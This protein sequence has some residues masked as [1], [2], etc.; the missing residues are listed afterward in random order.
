[1]TDQHDLGPDP[2]LDDVDRAARRA[3]DGLRAHV[4]RTVEP[5]LLL[6]ALPPAAPS[7][8]RGRLLAAAAVAAL[9]IGTVAVIGDGHP[10][11]E[12]SRLEVDEDGNKLPAPQAG[13]L[14]ALGPSD[15]RDSIQL[16]VTVEPNADL[17]DGD[18]VTAN[19]PG[20]VAGERVGIVQCASE[21]GEGNGGTREARVGIDA[22]DVGGVAYANADADGVATGTFTVH[23]VLTTPATGTVDCAAEARRCIVAMGALQDYDRS[24]GFGLAFRGGGEPVD[25]PTVTVSPTDGLS[26][27]DVVHV[28]GKG[29]AP[30]P[31]SLSECAIDPAGCWTVGEPFA[32]TADEVEAAGLTEVF[33]G[34]YEGVGLVADAAGRVSGDVPVWRFL[35]TEDPSSY[36]DCAVSRC[37][38]RFTSELGGHS[39]AP[40]ALQFRS[41]GAAPRP[42]AIAVSPDHDVRRGQEIVVRGA[43]FEPGADYSISMCAGRPGDP[44][45]VYACV[46]PDDQQHQIEDDG[47]FAR[48]FQ[49]PDISGLSG[50]V[51]TTTSCADEATC[52][53]PLPGPEQMC[54]GVHLACTI[55][56]DV[57]SDGAV[58][59]KPQFQA[60][61]V[62]VTLRH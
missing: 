43:G 21:A 42:P 23:R 15:G 60:V 25:I 12:R 59:G 50:E 45:E 61:P 26:D 54:D 27:G 51:P 35:P 30:G 44:A 47:G 16:P 18:V 6:A 56:V 14:T 36:I 28:E 32:L 2:G 37:T 29:F 55:R 3:S 62:E 49:V 9:L 40:P 4:H 38:L 17:D 48:L 34:A 11:D 24:G 33:G 52:G 53:S 57:Y 7:N 5:E 22:C 46:S 58:F 39:P 10:R 13:A 8:Q 41:G 20:F 1:M 19:G 31:V